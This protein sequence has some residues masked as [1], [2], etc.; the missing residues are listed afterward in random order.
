MSEILLVGTEDNV[1]P[2]DLRAGTDQTGSRADQSRA[3][4]ASGK[5]FP[6]DRVPV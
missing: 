2:E 6:E 3:A 4:S 1:P 5:R